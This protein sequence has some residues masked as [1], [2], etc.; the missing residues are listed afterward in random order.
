MKTNKHTTSLRYHRQTNSLGGG[1]IVLC[2]HTCLESFFATGR[3][4]LSVSVQIGL[5]GRRRILLS[6]THTLNEYPV[7]DKRILIVFHEIV[8]SPKRREEPTIVGNGIEF[9][10][11]RL[12]QVWG[13]GHVSF[14]EHEGLA[15]FRHGCRFEGVVDPSR[16]VSC[17]GRT[18]SCSITS[19]HTSNYGTRAV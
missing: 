17:G 2:D 10:D 16:V 18:S 4:H 19:K 11:C 5:L 12:V 1:F 14:R 3:V 7:V 6:S 8:Q 9:L 13:I 15:K